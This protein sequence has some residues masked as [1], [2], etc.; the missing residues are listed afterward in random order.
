MIGETGSGK[1]S[2]LRTFTTALM[3]NTDIKDNYR[4]GPKE[5]REL[6][7]TKRVKFYV[8][9][10]IFFI[11]ILFRL[12]KE[13]VLLTLQGMVNYMLNIMYFFKPDFKLCN[14]F[15]ATKTNFQHSDRKY[16]NKRIKH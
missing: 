3:S 5:S 8:K 6:S 7:V 15:I 1:S 9:L 4:V 13:N 11:N 2:F 14:M 10:N 16:K 12:G